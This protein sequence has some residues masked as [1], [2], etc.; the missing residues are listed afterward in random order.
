MCLMLSVNRSGSPAYAGVADDN[1]CES[2]FARSAER[3]AVKQHP[4]L[5]ARH[6][7]RPREQNQ[8]QNKKDA[9]RDGGAPAERHAASVMAAR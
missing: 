6:V 1:Q 7:H 8:A 3:D 5:S 4:P 2:E 9:A